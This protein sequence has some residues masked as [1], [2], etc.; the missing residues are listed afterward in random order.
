MAFFQLV[1]EPS[2]ADCGMRHECSSVESFARVCEETQ[3]CMP[4]SAWKEAAR[5]VE[6]EREKE[7]LEDDL[8]ACLGKIDRMQK[9]IGEMTLNENHDAEFTAKVMKERDR[10]LAERVQHSEEARKAFKRA[11][12]ASREAMRRKDAELKAVRRQMKQ[13]QAENKSLE[14]DRDVLLK[15]HVRLE[16]VC[17]EQVCQ[18]KTTLVELQKQ[19]ADLTVENTRLKVCAE[20]STA[21]RDSVRVELHEALEQ[22][23]QLRDQLKEHIVKHQEQ[24]KLNAELHFKL[25]EEKE[26]LT[27]KEQEDSMLERRVKELSGE[28]ERTRMLPLER[29]V[30]CVSEASKDKN[31]PQKFAGENN[32]QML[33]E[34]QQKF[35]MDLPTNHEIT[36]VTENAG[37]MWKSLQEYGNTEFHEAFIATQEGYQKIRSSGD[38]SG[39][40]VAKL[41]HPKNKRQSKFEKESVEF[42]AEVADMWSATMDDMDTTSTTCDDVDE[43]FDIDD[44]NWDHY[45]NTVDVVA[46]EILPAI[47]PERDKECDVTAGEQTRKKTTW[48]EL[49]RDV[50]CEGY[51]QQQDWRQRE[52]PRQWRL[53]VWCDPRR[54]AEDR[55]PP[56]YSISFTITITITINMRMKFGIW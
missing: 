29:V 10:V 28:V 26:K 27:L 32:S 46:D 44:E 56:I 51:S 25:L 53:L 8:V 43:K 30:T 33:T 4:A 49:C 50:K 22:N 54:T 18:T 13:A 15:E 34:T 36:D 48:Y 1:A 6:L 47:V 23:Y 40:E 7:Q 19:I 41:E 12:G 11:K 55:L 21:D 39:G 37:N 3:R 20:S 42:S 35:K 2:V 45:W 5:I 24:E 16:Q 38:T 31:A 52:W 14:V 9:K 17:L